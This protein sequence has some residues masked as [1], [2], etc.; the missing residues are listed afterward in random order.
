VRGMRENAGL[1]ILLLTETR[2]S[3]DLIDSQLPSGSAAA[4][5]AQVGLA[6][7]AI[8]RPTSLPCGLTWGPLHLDVARRIAS[9]HG[10]NIQLTPIQ[11]R[12]MEVLILAGGSVVTPPEL[13]RR[14]WGG[15]AFSDGE[16][17]L[18]H[19]RRIRKKIEETPSLP[20][21]LLTVRGEGYRLADYEIKPPTIDLRDFEEDLADA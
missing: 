6:L 15:E 12:I 16:R 4:D 5:I 10:R 14:I 13:S 1:S 9:W 8:A 11:F 7:I 20:S 19:I 2:H 3:G 21:F 17:I 18:Q